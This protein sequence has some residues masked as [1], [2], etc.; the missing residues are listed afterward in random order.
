MLFPHVF[1]SWVMSEEDRMEFIKDTDL[2][3]YIRLR[4]N[5]P[6]GKQNTPPSLI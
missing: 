5:R 6:A 4:A 3:R 2:K 1:M